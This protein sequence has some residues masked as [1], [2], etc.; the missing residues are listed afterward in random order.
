MLK[1]RYLFDCK[2]IACKRD[3]PKLD[4]MVPE[5]IYYRFVYFQFIEYQYSFIESNL[6]QSQT[7]VKLKLA[8]V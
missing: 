6:Y 7:G 1:G 3:W 4:D 2:C 8:Q 5:K